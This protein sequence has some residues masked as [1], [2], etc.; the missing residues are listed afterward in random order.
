MP[1]TPEGLDHV[2]C[3]TCGAEV[4]VDPNAIALHCAHCDLDFFIDAAS[5]SER[6][7]SEGPTTNEAELDAARIRQRMT[8]VR[9]A[10]RSRSYAI[11]AMIVCAVLVI[12]SILFA[13]ARL[14][15][16]SLPLAGLYLLFALVGIAGTVYF[17]RKAMALHREARRSSLD[18]PDTPPDFSHLGDGSERVRNLE[19]IR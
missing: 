10:Y 6:P 8:M 3:P 17:F 7:T 13:L 19:N 14:R 2:L 18:Q 15:A 11:I 1:E 4:L 12:Q 5:E 9:S 16:R